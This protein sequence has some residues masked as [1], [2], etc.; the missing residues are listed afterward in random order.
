MCF[1]KTLSFP[2]SSWP[3]TY[4]LVEIK[5]SFVSADLEELTKIWTSLTKEFRLSA[6]Y[7]ISYVDIASTRE[8]AVAP[9]VVKPA[10][11]VSSTPR[12]PS[13]GSMRPLSG[14]VG[15][16]LTFGGRNF[17]NWQV[18]VS[19]GNLVAA[20]DVSLTDDSSFT[21]AIPPGLAPGIYEV[22]VDVAGLSRFQSVVEVKP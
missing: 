20:Q 1:M 12:F 7:E 6:V 5:I 19:I 16:A 17:T 22:L 3:E 4:A 9:R 14:K 10:V 2:R 21:V 11:G 15:A 18:T 8:T 13:V